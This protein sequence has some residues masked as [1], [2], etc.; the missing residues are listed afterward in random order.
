M[1]A[2]RPRTRATFTIHGLRTPEDA[3]QLERILL[4]CR[5]VLRA[6]VRS[7]SHSAKIEFDEEIVPA[8][9]VARL[10]TDHMPNERAERLAASILLKVPSIRNERTSQLPIHILHK[11]PGVERATVHLGQQAIEVRLKVEGNLTTQDLMRALAVE[12]IVSSVI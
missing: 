8:Q 11:V 10:I 7:K 4:G 12:G 6:D 9:T 5:G 3:L 1:T 2:K